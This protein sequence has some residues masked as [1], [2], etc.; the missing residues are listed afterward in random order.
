MAMMNA[1]FTFMTSIHAVQLTGVRAKSLAEL[2]A[3]LVRVDHASVYHHTYRF[4]RLLHFL[5][6]VPHSDFAYWIGE[7]L[8]EEAM[9]EQIAAL[10]LRDFSSLR[11]LQAVLQGIILKAREDPRRWEREAPQGL[12]FHFCRSISIVLPTGHEAQTLEDFVAGLGRIDVGS[13]FYHLVEAP[14]RQE[15][16]SLAPPNDFSVWLEKTLG[17]EEEARDISLLNPFAWD[18]ETLRGK[19][20]ERLG[21][22]HLRAVVEKVLAR[23]PQSEASAVIRAL[24]QK[25]RGASS[26]ASPNP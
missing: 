2:H 4:L 8:K 17:L 23:Q 3:G 10:D 26:A 16:A 11:E 14:L 25:W 6:D 24:L 15:E 12:E 13:L 7:T 1:S 22:G 9:A 19:I 5:P 20:I 21:R 18:L